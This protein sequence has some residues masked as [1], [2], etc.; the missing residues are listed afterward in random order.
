MHLG[1]MCEFS[2]FLVAFKFSATKY[3]ETVVSRLKS[4]TVSGN[5]A[6][7]KTLPNIE[8]V[9]RDTPLSHHSFCLDYPTFDLGRAPHFK[10]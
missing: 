5:E 8:R 10:V 4:A 9:R 3:A 1:L 7:S 2:S 6:F